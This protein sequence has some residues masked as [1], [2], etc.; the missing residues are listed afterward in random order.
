MPIHY[1]TLGV[2]K[3]LL[4]LWLTYEEIK[5][6]TELIHIDLQQSY[7]LQRR[8]LHRRVDEIAIHIRNV[9]PSTLP[10]FLPLQLCY[11]NLKQAYNPN[12]YSKN[13]YIR[14]LNSKRQSLLRHQRLIYNYNRRNND[15]ARRA[16]LR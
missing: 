10:P 2:Y 16:C 8:D 3:L 13:A 11:Q 6:I 15:I 4:E 14:F 1:H 9:W 12:R 5:N 7:I